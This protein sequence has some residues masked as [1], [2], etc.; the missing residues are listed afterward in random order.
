MMNIQERVSYY[1]GKGL[2]KQQ[3][4]NITFNESDETCSYFENNNCLIYKDICPSHYGTYC[5]NKFFNEDKF[6]H[7]YYLKL[8][9]LDNNEGKCKEEILKNPNYAA[10]WYKSYITE[11]IQLFNSDDYFNKFNFIIRPGD[12]FFNTGV[13]IITKTRPAGESLNVLLNLDKN[14]HWESI[15]EVQSD[16]IPFNQKDNKLIWRG[17]PN[18]FLSSTTRPS[19]KILVETYWNHPNE[20]ID[21]GFGQNF[22]GINGKG[23]KTIKSQL[24]SKFLISVEG[25]DVAT[26]LKWMMYS[27]SVVL[28]P[29]PT[30]CSWFMEDMLE[31]Y[32]HY[33]PLK[34]D[35]SDLE[36]QYNW[37]LNNLD[38]C[39]EISK[40]GTKY[41]EQF[42]DE[43]KEKLITNLVLKTYAEKVHV[44]LIKV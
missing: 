26:G 35:F 37:C 30:M 18:G 2:D 22:N 24:Q 3:F 31:P 11:I 7:L 16:D 33:I 9:K 34:N 1:I 29:K 23:R 13:P 14:R 8:L 41:V 17:A 32:V 43:E 4:W 5:I 10:G 38:K 42:L 15:K 21:I 25:G 19:R 27:N 20:M 28:M 40:N 36:E 6:L 39:E 12:V 44:I